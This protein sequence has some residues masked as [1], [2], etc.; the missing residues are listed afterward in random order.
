MSPFVLYP[1][2]PLP[3]SPVPA[4]APHVRCPEQGTLFDLYRKVDTAKL[5]HHDVGEDAP[6]SR[7]APPRVRN[8]LLP[9]CIRHLN[10]HRCDILLADEPFNPES[11]WHRLPSEPTLRPECAFTSANRLPFHR[12]LK[13]RRSSLICYRD[14]RGIRGSIKG[15]RF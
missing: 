7:I 3:C 4:K 2:S 13:M 8:G 12:C 5:W 1:R 9:K 11:H 10:D 15:R 14:F 6:I